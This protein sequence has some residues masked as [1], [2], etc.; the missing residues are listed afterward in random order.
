MGSSCYTYYPED[1]QAALAI[2]KQ[3]ALAGENYH[4]LT[5]DLQKIIM[6][7]A[8]EIKN[9]CKQQIKQL[10]SNNQII[11]TNLAQ[12]LQAQNILNTREINEIT[13]L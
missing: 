1:Q 7:K 9:T 10:L 3:I 11:L 12:A 13:G 4:E 2:A 5:D 8:H 6:H